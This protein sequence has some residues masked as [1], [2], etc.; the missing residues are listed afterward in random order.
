MAKRSIHDIYCMIKPKAK[1]KF[2]LFQFAIHHC[3]FQLFCRKSSAYFF[4]VEET[5]KATGERIWRPTAVKK[6]IYI[7]I[8]S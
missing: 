8:L 2:I 7:F 4:R 6:I 5:W 3:N 1:E